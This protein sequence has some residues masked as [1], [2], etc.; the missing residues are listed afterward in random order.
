VK[1]GARCKHCGAYRVFMLEDDGAAIRSIVCPSGA[2]CEPESTSEAASRAL[3][4]GAN[5]RV[6]GRARKKRTSRF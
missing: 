3:A 2:A 1:L 4:Q 6:M 5:A